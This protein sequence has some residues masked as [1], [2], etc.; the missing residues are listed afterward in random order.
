ME[1]SLNVLVLLVVLLCC[2]WVGSINGFSFTSDGSWK[3]HTSD[4]ECD[5]YLCI[6]TTNLTWTPN[7]YQNKFYDNVTACDALLKRGV[8][9]ILF[10]GDSY[11]RH[12]YAAMLI[13]LNGNYEAGSLSNPTNTPHCRYKTQFMEKNCNTM[14]LNHNGIVCDGKIHLDPLLTGYGNM[15]DCSKHNG[16]VVL[17]SF[18]NHQLGRGRYGINNATLFSNLFATSICKD[19]NVRKAESLELRSKG[20]QPS[21]T[22]SINGTC[23]VW[24]VSTHQRLAAHYMDEAPHIV[25]DYNTGMRQ[26][27]DEGA[28]GFKNYVD[29]YNM[30]EQLC[31]NHTELAK[32]HMS[33][34]HVHWGFEANLQK[35]QI[36]LNALL[37][38]P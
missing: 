2:I 32:Q 30:T 29:V 28:C 31:M 14:Q 22:G 13:T 27:F 38:S 17:W 37:S 1:P 25:K 6:P 36:I 7:T 3:E 8:R 23:S 5:H 19:M 24:W 4:R 16:T 12:I 20:I 9:E 15:N 35:A 33:F 10:Y 11:M 34:D 18:G 26:F 21:H